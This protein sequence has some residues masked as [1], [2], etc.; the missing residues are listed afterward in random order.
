[1]ARGRHSDK[2]KDK[3]KNTDTTLDPKYV[4][5]ILAA[6]QKVKGQKQRPSEDRISHVLETSYGLSKSI[7][8]EQLELCVKHGKVLKVTFKGLSSYKNPLQ[9]ANIIR[10]TIEKPVDFHAYATEALEKSGEDGCSI[11][12]VEKYI[13]EHYSNLIGARTDVHAHVKSVLKKGLMNGIFLKEGRN[14]RLASLTKVSPSN[15]KSSCFIN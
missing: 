12:A 7:I 11:H 14:Y 2:E 4:L 6:I 3:D 8:S 9:A 5:W 15:E 1:M 13:Q 10:G